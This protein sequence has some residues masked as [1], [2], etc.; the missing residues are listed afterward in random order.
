MMVR[1]TLIFTA[2]ICVMSLSVSA[3][4]PAAVVSDGFSDEASA[5]LEK[6]PDVDRCAQKLSDKSQAEK[7]K[8]GVDPV[9]TYAEFGE[10]IEKCYKSNKK[11]K[12]KKM[13]GDKVD[14]DPNAKPN[15]AAEAKNKRMKKMWQDENGFVHFPDGSISNG[16]VD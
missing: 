8:I 12:P 11:S 13:M 16:P 2:T 9:T 10:F 15:G 1:F 3:Q 14:D 4:P 6:Y 5:W 7:K